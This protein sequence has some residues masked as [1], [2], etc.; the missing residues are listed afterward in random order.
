MTKVFVLQGG[1]SSEREVSLL[2]G[3]N[4]SEAAKSEGFDVFSYDFT[5]DIEDLITSIKHENPDI[6]FNALHGQFGEDGR[7]QGLLDLMK[8]K[9]THSGQLASTICMNKVITNALLEK[10]NILVPKNVVSEN[11]F[12]KDPLPRP[13]VIKPVDDGSSVGVFIVKNNDEFPKIDYQYAM[14][15]EYIEGKELT[16]TVFD[17][18][19]W[20]ITEIVSLDEGFYDYKHKYTDGKARHDLPANLPE[21]V[22]KK[23]LETAKK[24][25]KILGCKGVARA[26]FRYDSKNFYFLEMNTQPGMTSLSLSPEQAKHAGI[27]YQKFVRKIIESALS[28][29]S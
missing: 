19:A 26:D 17:G 9:Y 4:V 5:G 16:V 18:K 11:G 20:V 15:E 22:T 27:S 7:I 3:E 6:V 2:S 25:Y 8:V 29:D 13:F 24:A 23:I 28:I 12:S 10:N 1:I 21:D 14:S